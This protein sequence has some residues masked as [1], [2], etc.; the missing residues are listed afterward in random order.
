MAVGAGMIREC[1]GVHRPA[2]RR[3][4]RKQP[5]F[6]VMQRDSLKNFKSV[7]AV[8]LNGGKGTAQTYMQPCFSQKIGLF[9]LQII[10]CDY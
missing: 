2:N 4:I 3:D 10:A 6:D 1:R 8:R 5:I 7:M 9:P